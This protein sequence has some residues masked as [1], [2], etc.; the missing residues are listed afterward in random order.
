M[1]LKGFEAYNH[2]VERV[3]VLNNNP[4]RIYKSPQRIKRVT[5]MGKCKSR[6]YEVIYDLE[7]GKV[8]QQVEFLN[9]DYT[10][11]K[12]GVFDPQVHPKIKHIESGEF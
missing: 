4:A 1:L 3:L 2:I 10:G 11:W 7:R 9:Q 5:L 8:F 12:Q 6:I